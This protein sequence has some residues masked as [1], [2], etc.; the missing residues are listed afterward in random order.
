MSAKELTKRWA[1]FVIGLF[2]SGI[3]VAITRRGTLGVSPISSVPNIVSIKWTFWSF[4][5]WLMLGNILML[6]AQI[7]ILRKKFKI[8]N[9]LQI[10]LSFLFG[11][12]TDFGVFMSQII[13]GDIYFWRMF[14]VILG[15]ATLG[16]G[17]AI[18]VVGDV[19]LNSGEALVKAIAD[20][21]HK[22]FSNVKIVFDITCVT[23]SIIIS[24]IFFGKVVGAREGTIIAAICTGIAVQIFLPLI[25]KPLTKF[26]GAGN[27][28]KE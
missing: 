4:G 14:C 3:G 17:I 16:F 18:Q 1:L 28:Q 2:F 15:T 7:V 13:P 9:L 10:P 11:W 12:F 27:A 8:V 23:T 5:T 22:E 24:F 20:T 26:I 25:R 6:I 19:I 21:I